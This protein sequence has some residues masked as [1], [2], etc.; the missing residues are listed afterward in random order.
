MT[1][2]RW[3]FLQLFSVVSLNLHHLHNVMLPCGLCVP[4]FAFKCINMCKSG[5]FLKVKYKLYFK[6]HFE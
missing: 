4:I 3:T 2:R 5:I 1:S 6:N